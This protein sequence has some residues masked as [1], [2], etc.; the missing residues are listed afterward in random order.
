MGLFS[1]RKRNQDAPESPR[2]EG[3]ERA[4]ED[5]APD[6]EA[7]EDRVAD[8][9]TATEDQADASAESSP[10]DEEA[11]SADHLDGGPYD[12]ADAPELDRIDLGGLQIPLVDGMELR[13]ETDQRRQSA[14][15]VSLVIDGSSLQL[16]AF[17]APKSRGLWEEVRTSLRGSVV[18]QGGTAET[19]P[20][21]FGTELLTRLP[22]RRAD[23][24]PGYRP[25]R[26]I[27][28]DGPRWFLRAILAGK[29]LASPQQAALFERIL[30]QVVVVRG[31]EAMAPQELIPL[32]LPGQRP[33]LVQNPESPLDPLE[34]GPE[35]T[36]I[37]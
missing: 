13:I 23:G 1:R 34:R 25:A 20:G 30:S 21:P 10:S 36:E 24:R 5:D 37:G 15:G 27:G 31:S 12:A 16:Q 7:A 6:G 33:G 9:V 3:E 17:A 19:R 18:E 4:A 14:T 8:D 32:N 28:I 35:I 22:L 2:A 26:F 11:P 29:A